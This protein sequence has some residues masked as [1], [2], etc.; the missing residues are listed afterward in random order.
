MKHLLIVF[1][2]V[3]QLASA[4][5]E[6][7]HATFTDKG[8]VVDA[9]DTGSFNLQGP[10]LHYKNEADG[11]DASVK[12]IFQAGSDGANGTIIYPGSPEDF[13]MNVK[14]S[15]ADNSIN[16]SYSSVSSALQMLQFSAQ[17]DAGQFRGGRYALN[18]QPLAGPHPRS[19]QG[20]NRCTPVSSIWSG[21]TGLALP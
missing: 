15:P 21:A 2:L 8:I 5:S 12:P 14:I 10:I 17:F 19:F 16:F 9:G 3:F 13:K 20:V 6:V 18:G 1:L 4:R 7:I 11:K